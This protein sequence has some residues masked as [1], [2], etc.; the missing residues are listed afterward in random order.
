MNQTAELADL[1]AQVQS[2]TQQQELLLY[3]VTHELRTPVMT[4]L[5]FA[6][7][8]LNDL[9]DQPDTA[10]LQSSLERIRSAAERQSQM[11]Q[12]LQ[13]LATLVRQP[14]K[15]QQVD[16]GQLL[17]ELLNHPTAP[18]VHIHHCSRVFADSDLMKVALE[19]LLKI[20]TKLTARNADTVIEF[21]ERPHESTVAYALRISGTG[22]DLGTDQSLLAMFRRLQA[23]NEFAG[24]GTAL[25]VA[26]M[27]IH[28][29][30][31]NLWV[32]TTPGIETL[33]YFTVG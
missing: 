7:L 9:R 14:L 13:Q 33:V 16:M 24:A 29:H 17:R 3:M 21:A 2:L 18:A 8:M 26:I 27:I 30:G 11:I 10:Q 6:D 20:A 25:L 15:P 28:R 5:G 12:D 19:S 4:I 32:A 22:L 31:G 23:G 1:Q